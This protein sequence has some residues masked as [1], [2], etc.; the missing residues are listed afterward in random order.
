MRLTRAWRPSLVVW[1]MFARCSGAWP[2][3]SWFFLFC[4]H[5]WRPSCAPP[6]FSC[7]HPHGLSTSPRSSRWLPPFHCAFPRHHARPRM[8]PRRCGP[9]RPSPADPDAASGDGGGGGRGRGGA[10][11][12][13]RARW[14]MVHGGYDGEG[15]GGRGEISRGG[16]VGGSRV[17]GSPMVSG[18]FVALPPPVPL[19]VGRG[20]K[21]CCGR[22][23]RAAAVAAA[24]HVAW[25]QAPLPPAQP[26]AQC[27]CRSHTVQSDILSCHR[28][29][30][31]SGVRGEA[32]RRRGFRLLGV[33]VAGGPA[34]LARDGALPRH[35][36]RLSQIMTGSIPGGNR[37]TPF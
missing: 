2:L 35:V 11:G 32:T 25:H 24:V 28:H 13:R 20:K 15:G 6:L 27:R 29:S 23:C 22:G 3:F 31:W 1:G 19:A 26:A 12:C 18:S 5:T 7:R 21:P 4:G 14:A 37:I 30:G 34:Q 8:V 33:K 9:H 16:S 10:P 17:V 36:A